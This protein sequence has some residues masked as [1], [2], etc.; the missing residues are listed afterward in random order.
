M[1][2]LTSQM[3]AGTLFEKKYSLAKSRLVCSCAVV[4]VPTKQ[5]GQQGA[6]GWCFTGGVLDGINT[7]T[8]PL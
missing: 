2:A 1:P 8:A 3:S 7:V 6:L 5:P 4:F